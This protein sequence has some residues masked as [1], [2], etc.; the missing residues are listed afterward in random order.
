MRNPYAILVILLL[1]LLLFLKY[2]GVCL[3]Y[4]KKYVKIYYQFLIGV[5]KEYI[6]IIKN[7][8]EFCIY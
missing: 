1:L 3:N 5:L 4:I 2:F 8:K 7:F 6:K